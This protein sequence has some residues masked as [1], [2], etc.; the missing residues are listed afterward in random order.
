MKKKP[1]WE[2][3]TAELRK[4]TRKYDKEELGVPGSPLTA[5]DRKL[6]ARAARGPGRPKVG[7]GAKRVLVS[8]EARL[9]DQADDTARRLG[10]TRSEL[11]ARGLRSAIAVMT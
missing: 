3:T 5:A 6:L 10:L 4:A 9:L 2:M 11:I 7:A 1:Y 8:I